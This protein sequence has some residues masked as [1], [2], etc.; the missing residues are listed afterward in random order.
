MAQ[1]SEV[2]PRRSPPTSGQPV[3]APPRG[4]RFR[5]T[6]QPP[7]ERSPSHRRTPLHYVYNFLGIR[8]EQQLLSSAEVSPG[9][10][11]L[12]MEFIREGEGEHK[13]NLGKAR[14]Y[15]DGRVVAEGPLQTQLGKF[16]LAGDGLCVGY[17]SGEA[18]SQEYQTPAR[19]EGGAIQLVE[20]A[21]D[22]SPYLDRVSEMKKNQRPVEAS[23]PK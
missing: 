1:E 15:I 21:V 16:T 18:V 17:D 8:P 4:P 22:K 3:P 11:I 5:S 10:H 19:F 6:G 2:R 14:L 9:K 7:R 20:V 23:A 13:E 12:G